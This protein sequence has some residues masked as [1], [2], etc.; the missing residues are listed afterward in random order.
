MNDYIDSYKLL[1]NAIIYQAAYDWRKANKA[2]CFS[3][4]HGAE[5]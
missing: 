5:N 1:A 3:A 4:L 2:N